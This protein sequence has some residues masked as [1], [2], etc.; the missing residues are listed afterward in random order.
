MIKRASDVIN[1]NVQYNSYAYLKGR[2]ADNKARGSEE[3]TEEGLPAEAATAL[4]MASSL[5][6]CWRLSRWRWA[7]EAS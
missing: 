2:T 1:D 6:T 5:M 3:E 4:L 7:A